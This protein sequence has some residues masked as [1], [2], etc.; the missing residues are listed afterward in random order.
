MGMGLGCWVLI[1]VLVVYTILG[2]MLAWIAGMVAQEEIDVKTGVITLICSGILS[3]LARF[4]I[5]QL[6]GGYEALGAT[7]VSDLAI[8]TLMINLIAKLSW[9]HSAI[10]AVIYT[11]VIT[12]LR[13]GLTSC[14]SSGS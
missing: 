10:I 11:V 1:I 13:I 9:K 5:V 12:A 14:S 4:G 8:L 7:I 6:I 3:L 2:F